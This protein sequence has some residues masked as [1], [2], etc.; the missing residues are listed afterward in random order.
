MKWALRIDQALPA[1]EDQA[2]AVRLR[3]W[4]DANDIPRDDLPVGYSIMYDTATN[5]L[6]FPLPT[7]NENGG[8]TAYELP[9]GSYVAE[10][11]IVAVP[12][13]VPP[14]HWLAGMM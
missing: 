1:M 3:D 8:V 2:E 11:M 13:K 9:D 7:K 6:S 4:L 14:G 12:A 10:F 5:M